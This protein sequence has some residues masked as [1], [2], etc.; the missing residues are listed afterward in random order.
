MSTGY[1]AHFMLERELRFF[2]DLFAEFMRLG[3]A[4]WGTRIAAPEDGVT[5]REQTNE[6][7]VKRRA[8]RLTAA[9]IKKKKDATYRLAQRQLK[10]ALIR[11]EKRQR[12]A[13]PDSPVTVVQGCSRHGRALKKK[14][15]LD[16]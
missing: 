8:E 10:L 15:M 11:A 12:D 2:D 16:L 7:E 14:K 13:R 4:C 3:A 6:G 1:L 9:L 5:L